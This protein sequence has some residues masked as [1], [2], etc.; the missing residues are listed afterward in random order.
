VFGPTGYGLDPLGT[1]DTLRALTCAD[2]KSFHQKLARPDNCVLAIFGDVRAEQVQVEVEKLFGSWQSPPEPLPAISESI[3][4]TPGRIIEFHEKTQA[5]LVLGFPGVRIF[6]PER[7]AL[8]VLQ[9]TCSDLGSRL[10]LRI[11]EELGL[12]YYVGAQNFLGLVPGYFAFYVGTM[13]DKADLVE[14]ELRQQAAL[15]CSEGITAEELKRTKAKILGQKKIA[16][17]D[18]GA[19]AMAIALDELYGM[20]YDHIEKD[21]AL[22]EAVTLEQVQSAARGCLRPDSAVLTVLTTADSQ[23]AGA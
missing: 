14:N 19:L 9:E 23:S 5:V 4:K 15:L 22:Y 11:R 8:E 20:G 3:G 17:Q 1:E 7:Y 18:L 21:D 13:P 6:D 16:R 10:F 2:A 12:A